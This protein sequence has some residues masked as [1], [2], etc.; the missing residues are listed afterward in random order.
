MK[1]M[2]PRK[3]PKTIPERVYLKSA[4][5]K[6]KTCDPSGEMGSDLIMHDPLHLR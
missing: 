6:L 3:R 4:S 2:P 5:E 1:N